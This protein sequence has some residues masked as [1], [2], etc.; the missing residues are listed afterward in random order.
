MLQG[1]FS[2]GLF[3]ADCCYELI[4]EPA[5]GRQRDL[6]VKNILLATI[7]YLCLC[8]FFANSYY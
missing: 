5:T 7:L 2:L 6:L 1:C 4:E 8:L 3:L